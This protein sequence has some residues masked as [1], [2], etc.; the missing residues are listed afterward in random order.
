MQKWRL[1]SRPPSLSRCL[2]G[3]VLPVHS[4]HLKNRGGFMATASALRREAEGISAQRQPY[5]RI[6]LVNPPMANIGAEF[7]MEDVPLRLEY[8]G[9]YIRNDVDE[10]HVLDL[11][12]IKG[13][14]VK[15]IKRFKPDLVGISINYISTH[16]N[17]LK[18]ATVASQLGCP[19]VLGGYHATAMVEDF[20]KLP[21]V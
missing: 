4:L 7:M 19:V 11:A 13:D 17:A 8:L 6:L 12:N 20:A 2:A 14:L 15:T 21:D 10:C 18:M 1:D 5:R 16:A 3:D 9:G